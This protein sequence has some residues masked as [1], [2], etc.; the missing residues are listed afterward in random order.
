MIIFAEQQEVLFMNKTEVIRKLYEIEAV[1]V[2]SFTLKSGAVSPLYIDLRQIIAF[3][4]LLQAVAQMIWEK[5]SHLQFDLLC[6]VPYTALPIATC[7]STQY[8]RPM[9]MVRK[10]VKNHGTKKRVEGH[11]RLGE[12]CL[13]VEDV[14]TSGSSVLDAVNNL[15]M[16]GLRVPY[17]AAFLDREQGGRAALTEAECEFYSVFT[18]PE[19]IAELAECGIELPPEVMSYV[20]ARHE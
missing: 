3:P 1:K 16:V 17:V 19:F 2:G 18:L 9:L 13:V 11:Y 12:S 6:G 14:V 5:V 20:E 8:D 10:E 4:K 7:L 15:K